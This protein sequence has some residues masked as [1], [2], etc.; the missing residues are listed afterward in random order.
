M[1]ATAIRTLTADLAD[2]F[3]W[4]ETHCRARSSLAEH[5]GELRL[6]AALVRNVVVPNLDGLPPAPLHV[7]VVGG[8]GA[9]KSTIVNFLCGSP[10]AEANP[11]AGFTRHPVAYTGAAG[12]AAWPSQ[13]GFLGPLHRL[14]TPAPSSLDDDVYQL[15]KLPASGSD[16]QLLREFVVWDCP[17]MTTWAASNYVP[18]LLEVAGLADVI[19]Y[20]ASDER[21]NDVVPTQFLRLLLEVGKPVVACLTKVKPENAVATLKH[22]EKEVLAEL[23][24]GRVTPIVIPF[25]PADV[26]ADPVHKAAEYRIPL[27]NQVLVLGEPASDAR[28]RNVQSSLRFLTTATERL[29]AVARDDVAALDAWKTLVRQGQ[30]DF[31]GRYR[32]EFLTSEKFRRF[33]EALVRLLELLELPGAGKFLSTTLWVVRTPYR[34][35]KGALSKVWSRPDV[36]S[37]PEQDVLDAALAGWLDQLRAES[38]RRSAQHPMWAHVAEGFEHGLGEQAR[39]RFK[40]GLQSFQLGLHDEVERTARAIYEE[41]EKAPNRLATMRGSKFLLD[42]LAIA[43][44]VALGGFGLHDLVLVPL[45]ASVS[46]QLVEWMGTAYVDSQRDATRNRQ[47]ALVSK[48]VSEPLAAWLAQWPATGGTAYERLQLALSR[49]PESIRKL[50]AIIAARSR[51]NAA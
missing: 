22:F 12:P 45:A 50:D 47:Q 40:S 37:I 33:D 29:L 1:D 18:R 44:S 38:L 41:L 13:A 27:L 15:R 46:H 17:D 26:L 23:P 42:A 3:G 10:S 48:H 7:V 39:E 6:A 2:D 4:L 14:D 35:V 19:V 25:L 49:V 21:Y 9:G 34:L 8:A 5:A 24:R 20:V 11:Q 43:G 16:G 31:D 51:G 32:R 28:R 36:S 30:T